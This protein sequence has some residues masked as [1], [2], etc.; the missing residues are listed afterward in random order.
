MYGTQDG[1]LL[2]GHGSS[3]RGLRYVW[4]RTVR[5]PDPPEAPATAIPRIQVSEGLYANPAMCQRTVQRGPGTYIL[6]G[7]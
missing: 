4:P 7:R 3:Y 6:A 1:P 5:D 2:R